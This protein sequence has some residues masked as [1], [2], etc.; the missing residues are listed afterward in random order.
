MTLFKEVKNGNHQLSHYGYSP[1]AIVEVFVNRLPRFTPATQATSFITNWSAHLHWLVTLHHC[2]VHMTTS[3]NMLIWIQICE[4]VIKK[5]NPLNVHDPRICNAL[6][7]V[8]CVTAFPTLNIFTNENIR[9]E[10]EN[11]TKFSGTCGDSYSQNGGNLFFD[12]WLCMCVCLFFFRQ[13][14]CRIF[15]PLAL[16][17]LMSYDF[18]TSY[19]R[20][21]ACN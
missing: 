11:Y 7:Y 4:N 12:Y 10:Q 18:L 16:F 15:F 2:H 5:L 21:F 9:Q 8:F 14:I 13:V 17:T 19:R 1:Y 20:I 6:I 3:L